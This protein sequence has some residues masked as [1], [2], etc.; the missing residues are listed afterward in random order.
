MAVSH[1]CAR[2]YPEDIAQLFPLVPVG[3]PVE[4]TYQPVKVGHRRSGT[5]V[6]V[7]RDIYGLERSPYRDALAALKRRGLGSGV[8]RSAVLAAIEGSRGV[9]VRLSGPP[10]GSS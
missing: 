7:H 9:P 1:G 8:D 2:L 3:M 10:G 6:E 5:F 4:F